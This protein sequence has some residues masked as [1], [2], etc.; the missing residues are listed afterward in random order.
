M[1]RIQLELP[2]DKVRELEE[3]MDEAGLKTKKD[4]ISNALTLF[5]WAVKETKSGRVIA[6]VDE[7]NQR[8]REVLMPALD[9][10]A[11]VGTP[12]HRS[13]EDEPIMSH[14]ISSK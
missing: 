7:E 14:A 10:F 3:L 12:A 11:K 6:S 5:K 8:Y 13:A 9:N 2:D 1:T 4:L